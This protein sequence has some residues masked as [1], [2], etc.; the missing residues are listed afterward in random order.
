MTPKKSLVITFGLISVLDNT[1]T[2][3]RQKRRR[4]LI[5]SVETST[6]PAFALKMESYATCNLEAN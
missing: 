5:F 6:S 3:T 1:H 2:G 4:P